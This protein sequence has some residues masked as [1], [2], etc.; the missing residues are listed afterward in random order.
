MWCAVGMGVPRTD[1]G[2]SE[3]PRP[4]P[5]SL[6]WVCSGTHSASEVTV[7]DAARANLVLAQF[8]LPNTHVLCATWLP[9]HRP[10]TA[11]RTELDPEIL[12][13]PLSPDPPE[14]EEEAGTPD[15]DSDGIGTTDTV[16]LGTQEGS[17]SIYSAG[18]DWRRCLRTVQLKDA[19]HSVV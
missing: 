16:W 11:D 12:E 17:I 15:A 18:S 2:N 3:V 9:G 4:A 14:P 10:L 5:P 19:V 6:V 13:D 8:V 1:G 7:M